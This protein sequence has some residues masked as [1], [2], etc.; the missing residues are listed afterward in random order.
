MLRSVYKNI[1]L[2][3]T[4][5]TVAVANL[6][7]KKNILLPDIKWIMF[8]YFFDKKQNSAEQSY[9]TADGCSWN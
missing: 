6:K 7:I 2:E 9:K 3:I 1:Y 8:I 5:C 4:Y